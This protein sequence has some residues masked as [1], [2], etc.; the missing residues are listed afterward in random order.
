MADIEV[1]YPNNKEGQKHCPTHII[2]DLP[3]SED[4]IFSQNDIGPHKRLAKTLANLIKSDE[5]GGKMIGLEGSWGAGKTS[6][7]KMLSEELDNDSNIS[8]FRFDAWAHEGD[9]LR[10]TYL[11]SLISHFKTLPNEWIRADKWEKTRNEI[12]KKCKH[13]EITSSTMPTSFGRRLAF[14]ALLVPIGLAILAAYVTPEIIDQNG[15]IVKVYNYWMIALGAI[16]SAGPFGLTLWN[17]AKAYIKYKRSKETN[18]KLDWNELAIISGETTTDTIQDI[19]ESP[20]PTSIEFERYFNDLLKEALADER[21]KVILVIDNL[22]R[23]DPEKALMN[24]ATLQTFVRGDFDRESWYK[25]V[26]IIVPY[27][28]E[29]I[30]QLWKKRENSETDRISSSFLDKSFQIR[31]EVAQPLLSNWRHYLESLA[32]KALPNH[33]YQ[34]FHTIYSVYNACRD[35]FSDSPTP[36]E[37]ILYINQIGSIHQQWQ[38]IY[39]LSHIAYYCAIRH[40]YGNFAEALR[41]RIIPDS[42]IAKLVPDDLQK[43]LAGLYYNVRA[44][45]GQ[46]FLLKDPINRALLQNNVSDLRTLANDHLDG[47][48]TVLEETLRSD[49]DSLAPGFVN[50]ALCLY[51]SG[52]FESPL[53]DDKSIIKKY[54]GRIASFLEWPTIDLTIARGVCAICKICSDNIVEETVLKKIKVSLSSKSLQDDGSQTTYS[55]IIGGIV[56]L[57]RNNIGWKKAESKE[58]EIFH[59]NINFEEWLTISGIVQSMDQKYWSQIGPN[60]FLSDEI[61]KGLCG[62]IAAGKIG[63]CKAAIEVANEGDFGCNC[64]M[65]HILEALDK[66]LEHPQPTDVPEC[67]LLI[68]TIETLKSRN[69]KKAEQI[70]QSLVALGHI[71]HRIYHAQTKNQTDALAKYISL[72][73]KYDPAFSAP[74]AIGQSEAGRQALLQLLGSDNRDLAAAIVNESKTLEQKNKLFEIGLSSDYPLIHRCMKLLIDS[75]QKIIDAETIVNSWSVLKK[76]LNDDENANRAS[77]LIAV[78]SEDLEFVENV[79]VFGF[80]SENTDLYDLILQSHSTKSLID[81]CR[82]G[83]EQVTQDDWEKDIKGNSGCLNLLVTL[84]EKQIRVSLKTPFKNA[85]IG[86]SELALSKSWVIPER[87]LSAWPDI[88]NTI[89]DNNMR[90]SLRRHLRDN[91]MDHSGKHNEMFFRLFGKEISKKEIFT[92]DDLMM[93]KLLTPLIKE[94]NVDT[95]QWIIDVQENSLDLLGSFDASSKK[96]FEEQLKIELQKTNE[97]K[98]Q[99]LITKIAENW[100]IDFSSVEDNGLE[101]EL[102]DEEN[103][104]E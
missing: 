96:D 61:E 80:S 85:L 10:R 103:N 14:L 84:L 70:F 2:E 99:L 88:L 95:L 65:E 102:P 16:L 59:L 60:T 48:W 26:W 52:I 73:C 87:I 100:G 72:Y 9:P 45:L 28:P 36:R 7:I 34:E 20:D 101:S 50:V 46:Q 67:V 97:D 22:D 4:S 92:E 55:E 77:Q 58:D 11:E 83:L 47:F 49:S 39:P 76:I 40:K 42:N 30:K 86:V 17:V 81:W 56:E 31:F 19:T 43:N 8:L 23:V 57:L 25:R 53:Y 12:N 75:Q 35:A 15:T 78:L 79:K 68:D 54:I 3:I 32:Y 41:K 37:L 62:Y 94:R 104:V 29:G 21:R 51:E 89:N 5:P 69:T 71:S 93:H 66:R 24:W 74:P 44:E 90:I 64:N 33:T 63:E 82:Q 6:V 13:S 38:D 98:A 27:D 1:G 18:K 91:A